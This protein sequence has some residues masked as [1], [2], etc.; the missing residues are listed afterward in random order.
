MTDDELRAPGPATTTQ[1]T[2]SR[3]AWHDVLAATAAFAA[4][5]LLTFFGVPLL[6]SWMAAHMDVAFAGSGV[7]LFAA[8]LS[9]A[10]EKS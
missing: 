9:L 2:R 6:A 7:V 4:V 3:G 1:R 10:G 8:V 5:L